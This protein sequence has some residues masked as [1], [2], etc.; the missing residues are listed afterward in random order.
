M[1]FSPSYTGN[2]LVN[3]MC[4]G[5]LRHEELRTANAGGAGNYVDTEVDMDEFSL[6]VFV[7]G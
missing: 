5:L 2:P 7:D 6:N 3:A 4:V 1:Y